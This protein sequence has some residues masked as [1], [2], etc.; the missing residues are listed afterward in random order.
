MTNLMKSEKQFYKKLNKTNPTVLE[1]AKNKKFAVGE[2]IQTEHS[3]V[4]L[5]LIYKPS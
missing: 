2:R 5:V 3:R 1:K 4:K